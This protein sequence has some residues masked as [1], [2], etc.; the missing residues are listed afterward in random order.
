MMSKVYR[1]IFQ[2]AVDTVWVKETVADDRHCSA[3]EQPNTGHHV[4]GW[5]NVLDGMTSLNPV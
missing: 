3:R 4:L 1:R 5:P 2:Q